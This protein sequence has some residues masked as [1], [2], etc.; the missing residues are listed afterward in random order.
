[1]DQLKKEVEQETHEQYVKA[2]E[3]AIN[4]V[5]Q[6]IMN[7]ANTSDWNEAKTY[8]DAHKEESEISSLWTTLTKTEKEKG[9]NAN[10]LNNIEAAL[11]EINNK[12][13]EFNTSQKNLLQLISAK[14]KEFNDKYGNYLMEGTWQD[15]N[16]IDDTRYYLDA[17]NVAF[18]SSRPQVSYNI[19]V[20]RLSY[21]EQYSSK[22]FG[23]GDICY[24]QDKDFFGYLSDGVTPYKERILVNKISSFFDDPSRD[25]IT[26]QNYKTR[27]D[28]LFQRIAAATQSLQYSEGSYKRAANAITNNG[29]IDSSILKN[30]FET[31]NDFIMSSSN[32]N[33]I[34]DETG[35]TITDKN[36]TGKKTKIIAGGLFI[37]EDGGMTWKNA[38]SGKGISANILTAGT[39][40]TNEISIYNGNTPSFRWDKNGL[41]AYEIY[42]EGSNIKKFV[43]FDKFGIYGYHGTEDYVPKSAETIKTDSGTAFGL[44]WDGFFLK[45]SR[46]YTNQSDTMTH[47]SFVISSEDSSLTIYSQ[48]GE[49]EKDK[50]VRVRIGLLNPDYYTRVNEKPSYGMIIYDENG[51]TVFS[52][53]TGTV[54][55]NIKNGTY[56][57]GCKV[58]PN[59]LSGNEIDSVTGKELSK[60]D[61]S[62]QDGYSKKKISVGGQYVIVVQN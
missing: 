32:Q 46:S 58:T 25:T 40:N 47:N 52:T 48:V 44:T 4:D 51:G 5:K 60:W 50:K 13:N 61:L 24:I 14:H 8:V 31:N 56:V 9:A 41:T 49:N 23:L 53:S 3:E 43:R 10:E 38:I 29:T 21:L 12:L 35:I 1:M 62:S 20:L 16:Y 22:V 18:T 34:W 42:E 27:F 37:T 2:A 55:N 7:L 28:D 30:T 45:A 6:K 33:V 36:D 11:E 15:E 57:G 54:A 17:V 39:I 19:N 26:V 59:G